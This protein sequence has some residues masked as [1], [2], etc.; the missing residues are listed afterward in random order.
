MSFY[1][2]ISLVEQLHELILAK[3][4]G[5]P[6]QLAQSLGISR[7][8]LY[9]MIDELISL[10]LPVDY[11]SKSQ[12]YYYKTPEQVCNFADNVNIMN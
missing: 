10:N 5:T 7:T 4:T 6:K 1:L 12:T 2:N 8:K 11:S 3:N 9:I